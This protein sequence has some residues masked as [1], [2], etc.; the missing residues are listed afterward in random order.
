MG[1]LKRIMQM[2]DIKR[3][4]LFLTMIIGMVLFT[5]VQA[6][7]DIDPNTQALILEQNARIDRLESTIQQMQDA[8][9]SEELDADPYGN[10]DIHGFISQGYLKSDGVNLIPRAKDGTFELNEIGLNFTSQLNSKLWCGIQLLSRDFGQTDNNKVKLD[11]AVI[12]YRWRD[13]L[14]FRA[15]RM[16]MPTGLYTDTRDIDALRTSILLPINNIYHENWREVFG[17]VNGVG[18]HGD[19][20][21][22]S[23]GV[24]SYQGQ[25]GYTYFD[26]SD[27]ATSQLAQST[28][29]FGAFQEMNSD[30]VVFGRLDWYP[31]WIEGLRLG[32]SYGEFQYNHKYTVTAGSYPTYI[33]YVVGDT[34][35]WSFNNLRIKTLGAEY[36]IGDWVFTGEWMTTEIA[37]E[38]PNIHMR[39]RWAGVQYRIND[40]LQAGAYHSDSYTVGSDRS[41]P[42]N[43]T[44]DTAVSLRIDFNDHWLLKGEV[45]YVYGTKDMNSAYN[46]GGYEDTACWMWLLKTTVWF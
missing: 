14:G 42:A 37:S 25:Y 16:K 17:Y 41:A 13:A 31:D 6:A 20:M 7:S 1:T 2:M 39:N 26:S 4:P 33:G 5:E 18:I 38:I 32:T 21:T 8:E 10:I 34:F 30:Y 19:I 15:G 27:G 24:L 40:R 28:T 22:E 36:S 44:Q 3:K 12:D 23:W 43:L 11:W 29:L 35:T 9:Q 45:H 46:P